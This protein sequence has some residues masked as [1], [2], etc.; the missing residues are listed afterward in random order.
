MIVIVG[1]GKRK[2]GFRTEAACMYTGPLF[3]DHM[4]L[5]RRMPAREILILSAEYGLIGLDTVIDDYDT[6]IKD[7]SRVELRSWEGRVATAVEA[8]VED[9]RELVVVLAG[10][11]YT[12]WVARCDRRV[13]MPLAGMQLGERR[14]VVRA[15]TRSRSE[16]LD[17]DEDGEDELSI[18]ELSD[19]MPDQLRLGGVPQGQL[20]LGDGFVMDAFEGEV[21]DRSVLLATIESMDRAP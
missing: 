15:F 4:L 6:T 3:I 21:A 1:C 9:R 16:A 20:V 5:A 17:F 11:T 7:L 13:T 19:E 12:T 2:R 18:E 14:V 10:A 8:R